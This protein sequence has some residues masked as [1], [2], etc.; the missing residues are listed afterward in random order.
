MMR[1]ASGETPAAPETGLKGVITISPARP[2]PTREDIP[3]SAPLANCAFT[4]KGETGTP[5]LFT[6]DSEGRS[7]SLLPAGHYT[8]S[9]TERRVRRCGPFEVDIAEGKMTAVDWRCDSGMR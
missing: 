6:T 4:A 1:I 2:G 9:M 7:Q 3:N 5:I 8:I